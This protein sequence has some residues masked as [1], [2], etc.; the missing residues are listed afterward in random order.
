MKGF[1]HSQ[2]FFAPAPRLAFHPGWLVLGLFAG[3]WVLFQ[4]WAPTILFSCPWKAA[5]GVPCVACG[6]GRALQALISGNPVRAWLWNPL[7]ISVLGAGVLLGLA[8]VVQL[9]FGRSLVWPQVRRHALRWRILF[10][11][12]VIL[13]EIYLILAGI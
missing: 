7:F 13:N 6:S 8:A 2:R 5:L 11:T 10:L 12:A 4:L 3:G 1:A 9:L